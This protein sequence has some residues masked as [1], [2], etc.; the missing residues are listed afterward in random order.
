MHIVTKSFDLPRQIS[1]DRNL[2][3]YDIMYRMATGPVRSPCKP[4]LVLTNIVDVKYL[5]EII[6]VR[7]SSKVVNRT[8]SVLVIGK[9]STCAL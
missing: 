3:I 4:F 1:L 9:V 6:P 5:V 2:T 7:M 8:A